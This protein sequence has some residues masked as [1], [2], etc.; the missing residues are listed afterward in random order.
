MVKKIYVLSEK[1]T[2][3]IDETRKQKGFLTNDSAAVRYI[4]SE[5]ERLKEQE[6]KRNMEILLA[7]QRDSEE[8]LDLLLD[9]AN[10]FLVMSKTDTCIPV[11]YMESPCFA[12]SR[13]YQKE[14]KGK[15]KQ[16]KDFR[17]RK[18]G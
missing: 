15:L 8:K 4:I 12:K 5:Y 10:T 2:G 9:A 6:A 3:I 14:R 1:E 13:D 16:E 17:N 11:S 18:R 7:I